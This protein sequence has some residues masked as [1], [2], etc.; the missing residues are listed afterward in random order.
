MQQG[1]RLSDATSPAPAETGAVLIAAL[2]AQGARRVLDLGC[3]DGQLTARLAEAGFEVTG[4]DP[5]PEAIATARRRH[6]DLHF[7]A[8]GAEALPQ[9]LGRFDACC[10]V[11]ALHHIPAPHMAEV[12][13][14]AVARVAPRGL[15]HVIEPLA[16]G[17]FF[18]AMLPVEDE[19]LVRRQ[20][21]DT[22]E[23]LILSGRVVLRDLRRWTRHSRFSGLPGFV[24][25]LVR[26][27]PA[28]AAVARRNAPAL[29]RAWRDN[30][31]VQN[32]QAVLSQPLVCWSLGAPA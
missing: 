8:C 10:L 23:A 9:D 19:T 27:D 12:L 25:A 16:E 20:A 29:A 28:R 17:S 13:L 21:I 15:V 18:R 26:V 1:T 24:E 6:P 11:N 30:I 5:A 31:R 4:I 14:A 32:G 2:R 7:V 3:G 22:L